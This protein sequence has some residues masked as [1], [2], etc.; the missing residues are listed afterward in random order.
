MSCKISKFYTLLSLLNQVN[1]AILFQYK[2]DCLS[3]QVKS[4]KLTTLHIFAKQEY[5]RK[6]TR[7]TKSN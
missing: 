1:M 7:T 6:F 5:E 2:Q 3:N 4:R